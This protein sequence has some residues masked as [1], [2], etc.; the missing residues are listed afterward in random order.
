MSLTTLEKRATKE[1][2]ALRVESYT[3]HG[4]R[5]AW[6]S[7]TWGVKRD[8]FREVARNTFMVEGRSLADCARK[9]EARLDA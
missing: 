3:A 8:G 7:Y 5:H 6:A 2:A 1:G 4:E 9:L